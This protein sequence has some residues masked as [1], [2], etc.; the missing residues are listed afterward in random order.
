MIKR[1]LLLYSLAFGWI[2]LALVPASHGQAAF[3]DAVLYG[4]AGVGVRS[5]FL[6]SGTKKRDLTP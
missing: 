5:R 3:D 6:V 4:A 2:A 1:R